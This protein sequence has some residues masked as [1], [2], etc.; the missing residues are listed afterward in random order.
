MGLSKWL[1]QKIYK[2]HTHRPSPCVFFSKGNFGSHGLEEKKGFFSSILGLM[3]NF[4]N[5]LRIL[6]NPLNPDAGQ[7]EQNWNNN[8]IKRC[9]LGVST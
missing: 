2:S 7:P 8:E 3:E 9:D 4:A 1:F 5:G 6:Q